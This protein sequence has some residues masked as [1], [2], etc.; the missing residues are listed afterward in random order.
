MLLESLIQQILNGHL[1]C[2][3]PKGATV[4]T[5]VIRLQHLFAVLIVYQEGIR[6]LK[7]KIVITYGHHYI[8]GLHIV[9]NAANK[10]NWVLRK[11]HGGSDISHL[12]PTQR[13]VV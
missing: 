1:L 4:I 3:R 2:A 9:R 13:G 8:D 11:A 5:K 10:I 7:T 12:E 6:I